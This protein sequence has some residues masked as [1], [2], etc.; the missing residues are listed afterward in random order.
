MLIQLILF[1][2]I[3]GAFIGFNV[4]MRKRAVAGTAGISAAA[5][6]FQEVT[7]YQEV[8]PAFPLPEGQYES[9][10][11]RNYHGLPI[12]YRFSSRTEK[13]FN[14]TTTFTSNAWTAE[15]Q[16][17][18]R[19]PIHIADKRLVG[20]AKAVGE[21]F[22]NTTR[23]FTPRCPQRVETGIPAVDAAFVVYAESA[24]AARYL[25]A[26]TPA[27]VP[28]LQNWAELDVSVTRDGVTFNDPGMTNIHAAMGG[29]VG[30]AALG[31]D[32]GKRLELTIPVHERVAEL[33]AT[34]ARATA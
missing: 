20:V 28:L 11:V 30:N 14:Q 5:Q 31:F 23:E 9:H 3:G 13:T 16:A 26:Q 32:V 25:F 21:A 6:R 27:L 34:L 18:P 33:L 19:I 15:L 1:V 4:Y 17:P 2:V 24:E 10:S 12:H 7:G 22:S 29:V 8:K